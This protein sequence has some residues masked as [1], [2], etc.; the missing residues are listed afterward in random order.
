MW[1]YDLGISSTEPVNL[2]EWIT[3]LAT[4]F[5]SRMCQN[6]GS[7]S[8]MAAS[9][10]GHRLL[11]IL[12]IVMVCGISL[13][14]QTR[15]SL[16]PNDCKCK[17]THVNCSRRNLRVFPKG[18]PS[19]AT[20]ID[21]SNNQISQVDIK[22][23]SRFSRLRSLVLHHNNLQTIPPWSKFPKT[24]AQLSLHHNKIAVLPALPNN[25]THGINLKKLV[26]S[27]NR[28]SRIEKDAFRGINPSTLQVLKL[29]RNRLV[30]VPAHA[31]THLDNL[32][33]LDLTRN[34]IHTLQAFMLG[35]LLSL[36]TL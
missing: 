1:F 30:T 18:I 34:N 12:W 35:G 7:I 10:W 19:S 15:L 22:E 31:L 25:F 27:H 36:K 9:C 13:S 11:I 29:N 28:I 23:L 14:L 6:T 32:R 24:L 5:D 8:N 20:L 4:Y 33:Y 16:C 17:G 26:L 21:L 2:V 3:W